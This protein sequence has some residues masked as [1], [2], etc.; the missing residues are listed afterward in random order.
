MTWVSMF[1]K[2]WLPSDC[3]LLNHDLIVNVTY[4]LLSDVFSRPYTRKDWVTLT[5]QHICAVTGS[6]VLIPCS[7][8]PPAGHT[9]TRVFWLIRANP[10][11]EPKDLSENKSYTGRV[12]YYWDENTNKNNC[13]LQLS[14]VRRTDSAGYRARVITDI[15]K[16]QSNSAVN[17]SIT[18]VS[19]FHLTAEVQCPYIQS[20]LGNS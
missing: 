20:I 11:G 6:S 16:W 3:V 19:F 1:E 2:K 14:D 4:S 5:H 17:L 12:K 15:E 7:F 8:T 9:V 18:G 13:T 10:G